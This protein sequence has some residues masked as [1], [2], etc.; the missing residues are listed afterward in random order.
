MKKA[1]GKVSRIVFITVIAVVIG[2]LIYLKVTAKSAEL[3]AMIENPVTTTP[4]VTARE[5]RRWE[6]DKGQSLGKPLYAEV[7]VEYEPVNNYT[8]VD[9]FNEIIGVLNKNNWQ[10]KELIIAQPDYYKAILP[11]E[12]F[13]IEASVL[14]HDDRNSVGMYLDTYT[15]EYHY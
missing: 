4:L 7:T 13:I 10:K 8:K 15:D 11:Q 2:V 3:T 12:D 9:V 5:V 1:K 6:H 14:I